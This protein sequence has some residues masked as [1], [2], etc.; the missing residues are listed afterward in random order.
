M[1][2][3]PSADAALST[4][5]EAAVKTALKNPDP[6]AFLDW[7]G[8]SA[9]DLAPELFGADSDA[10]AARQV[11]L[12]MGRA[13]WNAL[14]Q[15]D[16]NYRPR[17][18]PKPQR[19]DACPCGSGRKYK[20]C[21]AAFEQNIPDFPPE[22]LL[23]QVL[24]HV[25]LKALAELPLRFI[26][27]E[28]LAAVAEQ[29]IEQGDAKRAVALLEPLFEE[30]A[31]LDE[32]AEWAFDM[33]ADAYLDI[34]KPK[35]R[36]QL[37]EKLMSVP[38]LWLRSAAMHRRATM[39][40]DDRDFAAAWQ[41]FKEAQRLQPDNV[42]LAHLEV[43]LLICENRREEAESRATFWVARLKRMGG[44]DDL[45]NQ[46]QR[47][48]ASYDAIQHELSPQPPVELD[49]LKTLLA[50]APPLKNLY[51]LKAADGD[52]GELTPSAELAQLET[53]WGQRF[54]GEEKFGVDPE[55]ALF[56]ALNHADEWLSWL[57]ANPDAL[58]SFTILEQLADV[59]MLLAGEDESWLADFMAPLSARCESLLRAVLAANHAANHTLLWGHLN[60]R[61]ALRALQNRAWL[62]VEQDA[63][64]DQ[65][66]AL[67]EWLLQLNPGDEQGAR[68]M[69]A[70]LYLGQGEA[71][72]VLD[73]IER[74]QDD[75]A[76]MM[77]HRA[78]VLVLLQREKEAKKVL[79]TAAKAWPEVLKFL[80]ADK[81][82]KPKIDEFGVTPGGKDEAWVYRDSFLSL[83]KQSGALEL[84]RQVAGA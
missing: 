38:N 68:F 2:A 31:A 23:A 61:P 10:A 28:Q 37:V 66:T 80:L 36:I 79:Q 64:L 76:E 72:K 52:L 39:Y 11:A 40:A 32:R 33:L 8:A 15:P 70:R 22:L 29:W 47:M 82:R 65:A 62:L 50:E 20:Q 3:N 6:A 55:E 9:P 58:L 53:T 71:Q 12:S 81:V 67:L 16:N 13:L 74:S 24:R 48:I 69:L 5:L 7:F 77:Y 1:T 41:V 49:Q 34:D 56:D 25:S 17:P 59:G 83:W 27:P 73:L 57:Q 51:T 14:P 46:L 60:N 42:S 75:G 4:L 35:K 21:C 30:M 18:L 54:F 26:S 43:L 44:Y 78:L 63:D 45:I 84:A 19:N